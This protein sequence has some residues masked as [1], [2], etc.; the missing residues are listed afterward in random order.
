MKIPELKWTK[1]KKYNSAYYSTWNITCNGVD[2]NFLA[3]QLNLYED[4]YW[5]QNHGGI[6]FD[7]DAEQF[8]KAKEYIQIEF[9]A[10]YNKY[11]NIFLG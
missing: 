9:E 11:K 6:E 3:K 4:V 7:N 5:E 1:N 2:M 10:F 8:R